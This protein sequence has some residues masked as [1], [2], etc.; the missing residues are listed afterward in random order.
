MT[1]LPLLG[2]PQ[3]QRCDSDFGLLTLIFLC[4]SAS[5]ACISHPRSHASSVRNAQLARSLVVPRS[6]NGCVVVHHQ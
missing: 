2:E 4:L 1:A 5:M 6:R 3:L